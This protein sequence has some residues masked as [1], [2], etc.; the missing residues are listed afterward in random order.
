MSRVETIANGIYNQALDG[1]AVNPGLPDDLAEL[2]VLQA[3]HETDGFTSNVFIQDNNA[4]G[5]KWVGSRYQERPGLKAPSAEGDHYGHYSNYLNSVQEIVDWLYRRKD[6]G[7]L[8]ALSTIRDPAT[9]AQLLKNTGYYG[10]P[11]SVYTAGLKRWASLV[12]G[13]PES[14]S[15]A[16]IL[17]ISA[18]V[19]WGLKKVS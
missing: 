10:A 5:Y 17:V 2:V 13:V 8:P 14:G 12:N 3:A 4:F 7:K 9:Y 15:L 1:S 19:I 6:E 11:V 18:F 16:T